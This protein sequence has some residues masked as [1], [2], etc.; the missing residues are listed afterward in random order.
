VVEDRAKWSRRSSWD[1]ADARRG[2]PMYETIHEYDP[3]DREEDY[4]PFE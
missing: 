1:D 2:R 3:L 4:D